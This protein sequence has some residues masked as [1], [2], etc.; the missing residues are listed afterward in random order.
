MDK[1]FF[2]V[3]KMKSGDEEAMECFVRQY[4][5]VILQY[6]RYRVRDGEDAKD[7]T[8]ETFERFF[9]N[10]AGY[11]HMG[12]T[13]NYLYVIAGNLCRD[14]YRKEAVPV[15]EELPEQEENPIEEIAEQIDIETA[16]AG[17]PDEL[18]EV[19]ILHYFQ[20]RKLREIADILQIGLPL[21]KYRIKR[22][23]EQLGRKL[24]K[25]ETT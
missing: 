9:R 19:V 24:G 12:K 22:A 1:D 25:E 3:R 23:K 8:Q 10:L 11:R 17:L 7:I 5:P 21:V 15:M 20:G 6:C 13:V 18:S 16:V 4:Y 14:F 2:L